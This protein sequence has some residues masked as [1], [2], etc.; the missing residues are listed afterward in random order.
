MKILESIFP[1]PLENS[2]RC[3]GRA[4]LALE[5]M[6]EIIQREKGTKVLLVSHNRILKYLDGR[7]S[8]GRATSFG[9]CEIRKL[10]F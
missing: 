3:F 5:I 9:N 10:I 1:T 7:F 8:K 6:K 2:E 4:M